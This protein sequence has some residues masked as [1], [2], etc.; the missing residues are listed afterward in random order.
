M[1]FIIIGGEQR[2]PAEETVADQ[3]E[4]EEGESLEAKAARERGK[5]VADQIEAILNEM[6]AEEEAQ[7]IEG[8]AEVKM[9]FGHLTTYLNLALKFKGKPIFR[10]VSIQRT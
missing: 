4:E 1:F 7:T 8:Q 10:S 2:L 6:S 3:K 5:A 9:I